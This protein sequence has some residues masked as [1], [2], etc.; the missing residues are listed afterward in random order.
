MILVTFKR[1]LN[2]STVSLMRSPMIQTSGY[3]KLPFV[4]MLQ[5]FT[6]YMHSKFAVLLE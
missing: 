5:H 6:V 3:F 4:F 2:Y 1:F